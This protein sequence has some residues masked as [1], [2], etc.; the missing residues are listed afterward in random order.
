MKHLI[1]LITAAMIALSATIVFAS[2]EQ[3]PFLYEDFEHECDK[4]S[5]SDIQNQNHEVYY[6][7][8]GAGNSRGALSVRCLDDRNGVSFFTEG[9][10]AANETMLVSAQICLLDAP[11]NIQ[12]VRFTFCGTTDS[13]NTATF[14]FP[15]ML[16]GIQNLNWYPLQ[17]EKIFSGVVI[18]SENEEL[19]CNSFNIQSVTVSV[20]ASASEDTEEQNAFTFLLDDLCVLPEHTP[21]AFMKTETE[22]LFSGSALDTKEDISAFN[23][24]CTAVFGTDDPVD[25]TP[26]MRLITETKGYKQFKQSAPI[27]YNRLYRLSFDAKCDESDRGGFW[28]FFGNTP[29]VKPGMSAYPGYVGADVLTRSWQH[30][31]VY[32]YANYNGVDQYPLVC[33]FRFF[34]EPSNRHL[35]TDTGAYSIDNLYLYDLGTLANG[36]F[37]MNTFPV[38]SCYKDGVAVTEQMQEASVPFWFSE[39]AEISASDIV[40]PQSVNGRTDIASHGAMQVKLN[41]E[42]GTPYQGVDI[43]ADTKYKISF[44]AKCAD[45]QAEYPLSVILD[46]T[47]EETK[48]DEAYIVPDTEVLTDPLHSNLTGQWT[49]YEMYTDAQFD[50]L[51]Q[52]LAASQ[53]PRQPYLKFQIL[54]AAEGVSYYLDDISVKPYSDEPQK[55]Y[56]YAYIND[57]SAETEA[58]AGENLNLTY[59]YCH[60]SGIAERETYLYILQKQDDNSESILLTACFK[61]GFGQ[62]CLPKNV[63]GELTFLWIPIDET[64]EVGEIYQ[65]VKTVTE[66]FGLRTVI[67][68]QKTSEG[69][70]SGIVRVRTNAKLANERNLCIVLALYNNAGKMTN[71]A[72]ET[73]CVKDSVN[74]TLTVSAAAGDAVNAKLFIWEMTDEGSESLTTA[75]TA[76]ITQ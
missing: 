41:A 1:S 60:D 4:L 37:E 68:S 50:V 44:W 39:N 5:I 34:D 59:S 71:A 15:V 49:H 8:G 6:V 46:R 31:D 29:T 14:A 23:P 74:E 48:T 3:I 45:E 43:C 2:D 51:D 19:L 52:E 26:Y 70:V 11:D 35:E 13:G 62:I 33:L 64:G 24:T 38:G 61:N 56:P 75:Y 18:D 36:D 73:L 53:T 27:R 17:T 7:N 40:R 25:G 28:I 47:V 20:E 42:N 30:F 32:L 69:T 57:T 65:E 76:S 58:V 72:Y 67:A 21:Q 9:N 66:P 55:V 54:G 10:I 63:H 16:S 22:N 12:S